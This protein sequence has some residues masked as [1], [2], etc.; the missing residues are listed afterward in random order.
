MNNYFKNTSSRKL[1]LRP[2]PAGLA[3]MLF[4]SQPFAASVNLAWDASQSPNVGGYIVSYG[5]SSGKYTESVD[6]GNKTTLTISGAKEG[7]TYYAAVKAY[8]SA[9]TTE[10]GYS[11]EI[12][13]TIPATTTT[14]VAT[15]G[16]T[17]GSTTGATTGSTNGAATGG[18]TG[19]T[20]GATSGG[21]TDKV[22]S[23]NGL[24]A[25]YG[26]EEASGNT[27]AD[28]SGKGNHGT[29]REAVR[30]AKGRYGQALQFDGV[31]DWVT[32][33]DS[34]SLD[35]STSM[36]LEA[37][38][39][40]QSQTGEKALIMKEQS[41]GAVY[42]LLN[43]NA[44]VPAAGIYDG[45][46]HVLSGSNPLP[47]NQ[48]T[49]LVVTYDGQYGRLYMNG[50]EVAKGAEKSLI[51]PSN[52][53][54]RIGGNSTWGAYFK[55]LIDEVRIYNRALTAAEVQYNSKTAISVS[56]PPKFVMG[57]KNEEPWVEYVPQGIAQAYQTVSKKSG[58]VTQ[59]KVY[60]DASTT[61]TQLVAGIYKDN[62]GHPGAL[63]AQGKLNTVKPN[64]W[65][66]VSIAGAS[67]AAGKPYWI[68]I[69]GPNGEVGFLDQVGSGKGLME[70]SS[71]RNVLKDLPNT[72]TG[73]RRGYKTNASMSLHGLGH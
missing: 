28:A 36:T 12:S 9:R 25:A 41:G 54:L 10:S 56:N 40:P 19:G 18:T 31:N 26:F 29:I 43:A 67:V 7:V 72:W 45:Q 8:D 66:S 1:F 44:N 63:V 24:V 53:E 34:P 69:M 57:D 48:W 33:K 65:N 30:I 22:T 61:A 3:L 11:N 2:G 21:A 4:S 15:N 13:K 27:V 20:T 47:A 5:P 50:V 49:H 42:G 23:N 51:Q 62:K 17:T 71:G 6:V 32:V 35:L 52:G 16:G 38:V 73:S 59:V 14:T 64:A 37:W 58:V 46:Y 70:K 55:G 60:L 68:A 39:Y